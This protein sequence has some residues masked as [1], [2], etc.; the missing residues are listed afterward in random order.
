MKRGVLFLI[1]GIIMAGA[2][3]YMYFFMTQDRN[4]WEL[5][6]FLGAFC[7]SGVIAIGWTYLA[8]A[9]NSKSIINVIKPK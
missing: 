3:L 4:K 7:A 9:R 2:A 1:L 6:F 5:V 8:R